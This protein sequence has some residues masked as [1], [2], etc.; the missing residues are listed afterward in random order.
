MKT[1]A[2]IPARGGSKRIP[3]KNIR[4]FAG[5]PIICHAIKAAIDSKLFDEVMVSSNDE[6]IL[7]ISK[8]TG[9]VIPFV[10]SEKNSDDFST[11][12]DVILE[13]IKTYNDMGKNF[14]LVCCIYPTAALITAER[15]QEG[16][17]LLIK[18]NYDLVFP[19]LKYRHPIQ[20]AIESDNGRIKFTFP[21]F[22]N[23][24]TQDLKTNYHDSG[25][26]YWFTTHGLLE[27]RKIFTSNTGFIELSELEAQDIDS[28]S[29]WQIAELKYK[30]IHS[31]QKT[32]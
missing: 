17:D 16:K 10:R 26:F 12:D 6:E 30:L 7:E 27:G 3:R 5:K 20:R 15:L 31:N 9:A 24:R 22:E 1:L 29:D 32:L 8:K 28:E 4:D 21:E 25:Q 23:S 14:D 19:V 18:N 11:T 13:V 2:I